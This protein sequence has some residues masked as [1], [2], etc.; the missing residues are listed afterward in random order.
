MKNKL[1]LL[2]PAVLALI[3]LSGTKT[4]EPNIPFGLMVEFIR[5]PESVRIQDLRPEF[6]WI[7]PAKSG[8]QSAYQILVSSTRTNIENNNGDVWDSGKVM[9]SNSVEI[10]CGINLQTDKKYFWK[11]R[12]WNSKG[13]SSGYSGIQ[14]FTTG[15]KSG[16]AT[17]QNRFLSTF[18]RPVKD[19]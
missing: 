9:S 6:T 8:M 5:E 12:I 13:K 1:K 14:S 3:C 11:V 18:D 17:T 7:V 4:K 2:L 16:Y 19:H 15:I 10:E